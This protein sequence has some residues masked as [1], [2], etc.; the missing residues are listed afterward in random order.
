MTGI[1]LAICMFVGLAAGL[2]TPV[3]AAD[4]A[5][6][7]V[8][9]GSCEVGKK[10]TVTVKVSAPAEIGALEFYLKYDASILEHEGDNGSIHE[11]DYTI[12]E[13]SKTYSYTFKAKKA[14]TCSIKVSG[15]ELL[16]LY[17][18]SD[19]SN[20]FDVSVTDG[21]VTVNPPY[22]PSSNAYLKSLSIGEGSLS[23]SFAKDKYEYS[24]EVSGKHSSVTVSAKSDDSKAKVSV[25]GNK[26][27]KEGKNTVTVTVTAEDGKTQKTYKITV[28]RGP[29]PTNTPTPTPQPSATPTPGLTTHV[30]DRELTILDEITAELPE[31]FVA[32][33]VGMDGFN[34]AVASSEEEEIKLV[35][36][37]DGKLYVMETDA[38]GDATFYVLRALGEKARQYRY[39][40]KPA[41]ATVPEG[42]SET[43]AEVFD[44]TYDAY[45]T[46]ADED[47]YLMYLR[48]PEG[49]EGWYLVDAREET[50]QRYSDALYSAAPTGIVTPTPTVPGEIT[51]TGTPDNP[52]EP[53]PPTTP[54]GTPEDNTNPA[55][56]N[57]STSGGGFWQLIESLSQR[58]RIGAAI[59]VILFILLVLLFVLLLIGH[60]RNAKEYEAE[61][62][63]DDLDTTFDPRLLMND[64]AAHKA[65]VSAAMKAMKD[66][67]AA[68]KKAKKSVNEAKKQL[69][70]ID[71][72]KKATP[73]YDD[74]DEDDYS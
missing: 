3:M 2:V 67:E 59:I 73:E 65:K 42:F 22:E 72:K 33:T 34:I 7:T 56:A 27:L 50:I 40:P 9:G 24:A 46:E 55:P 74:Y 1:L 21:K 47:M 49:N 8:T 5:T 16:R 36:M 61:E 35:Q 30:D 32:E 13:K 70:K 60:N 38:N 68:E 44:G 15:E 43:Q 12:S 26:N 52:G 19:G 37:S 18:G 31:G 51:P 6:V 63:E 62:E 39:L 4:K 58:E 53:T 57:R 41:Y 71:D 23:P 64:D 45:R 48:S 28:T 54:T 11:V 17:P 20:A 25:S 14:G 29:A 10:I 66:A 69:S